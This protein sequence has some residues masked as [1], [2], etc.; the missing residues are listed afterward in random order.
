MTED[1]A[2]ILRNLVLWLIFNLFSLDVYFDR[3]V[4]RAIA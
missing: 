1:Y 3:L 2:W 4:E